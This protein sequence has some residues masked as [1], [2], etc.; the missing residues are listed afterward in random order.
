M[1]S[2]DVLASRK[3]LIAETV[4]EAIIVERLSDIVLRKT[5]VQAITG[6]PSS[7]LY[8]KVSIGEFAGVLL[9]RAMVVR[10]RH[11]GTKFDSCIVLEGSQGSGK[12]TLA[13]LLCAGPG[14]GYFGDAPGLIGLEMKARAELLT[15][16]WLV[17]LAE[18]SGLM[19]S[20]SENVK[21]F[22]SQTADQFRP[23]YSRVAVSRPRTS[24]FI[25]TTN[26]QAYLQ[27]ATGN[28]RFIPVACGKIDIPQLKGV[29]DQL[30]AEADSVLRRAV[31]LAAG[32]GVRAEPGQPLPQRLAKLLA[33]PERLR[34]VAAAATEERRLTDATE[35]VLPI[36]LRDLEQNADKLDNGRIF[37]ASADIRA[38][39]FR[40]T[41]RQPPNNG[42]ATLIL[43]S[44]WERTKKG[45]ASAQ[46][47][48]Y[49]KE[50]SKVTAMPQKALKATVSAVSPTV[51]A[52]APEFQHVRRCGDS[53]DSNKLESARA[54]PRMPS[55]IYA[56][57]VPSAST[58][59]ASNALLV[60][61][62]S[63]SV[64]KRSA[65]LQDE[66]NRCSSVTIE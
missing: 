61:S 6:L 8:R 20:E 5:T 35:D 59:S 2:S 10:A 32:H 40:R 42:L 28:R 44:G 4:G 45:R 30:F 33:L 56:S 58:V 15:G 1:F 39:I 48:G 21:A 53:G 12:S 34:P 46:V 51:S 14:D 18:L 57:S 47:R 55:D 7:T 24:V 22:L 13:Q 36:V 41:G 23:A 38:E 63:R 25:A 26:S 43:Q 3:T 37:L 64:P 17:E 29:R 52:N 16:R 9:I 54:R 62:A 11:P 50:P 66:T 65:R 49:S 60:R 31:E 27:D 19:R